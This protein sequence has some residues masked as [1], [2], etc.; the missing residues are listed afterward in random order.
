MAGF[1]LGGL[2]ILKTLIQNEDNIKEVFLSA[3]AFVVNG[4][5]LIL[6]FKVFIPM[7]RYIKTKIPN[8]LKNF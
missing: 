2:V 5:P 4:N 7:K 3:P 1:S 6:L 8:T